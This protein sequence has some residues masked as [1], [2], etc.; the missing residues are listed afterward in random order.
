MREQ[1]RL[2]LRG[3]DPQ[4][5]DLEEVVLAPAVV[6]EAVGVAPVHVARTEPR[7]DE[8][9]A[10]PVETIPVG[11]ARRSCLDVE[12]PLLPLP[13]LVAAGVQ[14]AYL[15]ARHRGARGARAAL[16]RP[17]REDH[18]DR[19]GGPDPIEDLEAEALAVGAV[20]LGG[21]GL[22]RRHPP[23]EPAETFTRPACAPQ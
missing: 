12:D 15:G 3:R 8:G 7:A 17:V 9:G 10:R 22:A 5:R 23:A 1:P 4:A 2:D 14:Q 6:V 16:P 21:K 18:E 11:R 19:L 20:E 13:D